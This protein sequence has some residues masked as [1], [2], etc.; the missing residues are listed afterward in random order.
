MNTFSVFRIIAFLEGI[1]FILLVG[2]AMP[3]K[4]VYGFE[5]ATQELGMAH[6]VLFMAYVYL[7]F[8]IRKEFAWSIKD[9]FKAFMASLLP[10]GTIIAEYKWFRHMQ[11]SNY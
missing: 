4:H 2:I 7:L 6:G 8:P 9:V 1:S 10:F 5:E 3:L 11:N